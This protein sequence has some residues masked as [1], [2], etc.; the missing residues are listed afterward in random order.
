MSETNTVTKTAPEFIWL[1]HSDDDQDV[2]SPFPT[3][4]DGVS[5]WKERVF[6]SDVGY[7]RGDLYDDVRRQRDAMLNAACALGVIGN[8]YCF[9]SSDRNPEKN[10]HE[11]ECDDLRAAIKEVEEGS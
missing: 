7:V 10:N 11:P 1:Q 3:T 9:C 6:T 5:W 4:Y 8:G 2:D